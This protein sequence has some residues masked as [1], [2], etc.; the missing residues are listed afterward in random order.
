MTAPRTVP[1]DRP[2][3]LLADRVGMRVG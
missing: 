2:G 1:N 3:A